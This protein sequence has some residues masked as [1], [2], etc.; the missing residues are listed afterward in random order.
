MTP[1]HLTCVCSDRL[2]AHEHS[3]STQ[4]LH[5]GLVPLAWQQP[6]DSVVG[7]ECGAVQRVIVVNSEPGDERGVRHLPAQGVVVGA[8]RWL[9]QGPDVGEDWGAENICSALQCEDMLI[10]IE[11]P[12]EL[13]HETETETDFVV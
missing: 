7:R 1:L 2:G 11:L 4:R 3:F 5:F 12:S 10:F 9:I 13:I 8:K 6:P